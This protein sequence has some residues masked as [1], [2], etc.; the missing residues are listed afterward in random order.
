MIYS[1]PNGDELFH[2][3][4]KLRAETKII[5]DKDRQL[6]S[7]DSVDKDIIDQEQEADLKDK[8]ELI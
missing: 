4:S 5:I 3:L 6:C 1:V 2:E 7:D 8:E